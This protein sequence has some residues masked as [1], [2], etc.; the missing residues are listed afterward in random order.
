MHVY[1][2][3]PHGFSAFASTQKRPINQLHALRIMREQGTPLLQSKASLRSIEK[4]GEHEGQASSHAWVQTVQLFAQVAPCLARARSLVR[5]RLVD[6][7]DPLSRDQ[8][9]P[10]R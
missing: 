6:L 7:I 4:H 5:E 1:F 8:A 3:P 2:A 9:K 10:T